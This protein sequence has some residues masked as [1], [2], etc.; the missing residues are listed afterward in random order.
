M[1]QQLLAMEATLF[2]A[3]AGQDAADAAHAGMHH[4]CPRTSN[5]H[6]TWHMKQCMKSPP[7]QCSA[8]KGLEPA[9]D[10]CVAKYLADMLKTMQGQCMPEAGRL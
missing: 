9:I 7:E 2:A 10:K 3:A 4:A 8:F 6:S 5:H 1:S